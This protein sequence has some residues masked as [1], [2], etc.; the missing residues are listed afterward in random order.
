MQN[1]FLFGLQTSNLSLPT[2]PYIV[3]V[4]GLAWDVSTGL[5]PSGLSPM[6]YLAFPVA[7]HKR[8]IQHHLVLQRL[9]YSLT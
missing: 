4:I 8:S 9:K 2:R 1:Q 7:F 3:E 5:K 6:A